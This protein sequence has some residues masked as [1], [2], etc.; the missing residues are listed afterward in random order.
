MESNDKRTLPE[1]LF[2][3]ALIEIGI[4]LVLPFYQTYQ[5]KKQFTAALTE[6]KA[7]ANQVNP[8][9]STP[10]CSSIT[11]STENHNNALQ[12]MM[13]CIING[14]PKVGGKTLT[15][16]RNQD[17]SWQCASNAA[18]K[19]YQSNHCIALP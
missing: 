6:I 1:I 16:A 8:P 15:Y 13:T 18:P 3:I 4:L 10:H 11:V 2:I 17:G 12:P 19:F 7:A 5:G 9:T 14:N